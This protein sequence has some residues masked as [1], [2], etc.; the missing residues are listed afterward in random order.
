[1]ILN[2]NTTEIHN[3]ATLVALLIAK[4]FKLDF[5]GDSEC[6]NESTYDKVD[7][8]YCAVYSY[9]SIKEVKSLESA[10]GQIQALCSK[11]LNGTKTDPKKSFGWTRKPRWSYKNAVPINVKFKCSRW[12]ELLELELSDEDWKKYLQEYELNADTTVEDDSDY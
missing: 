8:N 10:M 5:E 6:L 7:D 11:L 12:E 4:V 2:I 3:G 1:M 9:T